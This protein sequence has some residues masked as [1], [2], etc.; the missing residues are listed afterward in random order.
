MNTHTHTHTQAHTHAH[1]HTHLVPKATLI[2][3]DGMNGFHRLFYGARIAHMLSAQLYE[4]LFL[5]IFNSPPRVSLVLLSISR[6]SEL[7]RGFF[8]K[9]V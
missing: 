2:A 8:M 9:T 5:C 3:L 4:R 1:I 7:F 6:G